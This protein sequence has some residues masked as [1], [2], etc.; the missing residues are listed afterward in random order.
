MNCFNHRDRPAVA[1]CKSCAKALCEHCLTELPNGIACKGS[2]ENR[3]NMLNRIIDSNSQTLRA[4]RHQQ[5][6]LGILALFM[7]L[8][9][10]VFAVW[11]YLEFRGFLL[12]YLFALLAVVT[13]ITGVLKFSRREQY[14]N[15]DE[16]E[17]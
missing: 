7:G 16:K 5:R 11:A 9:C 15:P 2:C 13:L 17:S 14:P 3:V 4:A 6:S 10:A 12:P 1:I 8:G